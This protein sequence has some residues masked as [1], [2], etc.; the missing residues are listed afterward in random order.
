MAVAPRHGVGGAER[1]LAR[2]HFVQRHTARVEIASCIDRAIHAAGLLR[3]HVGERPSDD[4]GPFGRRRVAR[5]ERRNAEARQPHVAGH[6]IGEDVRRLDVFVDETALMEM[7]ERIS[8]TDGHAQKGWW[9]PR[10][11][12]QPGQKLAVGMLDHEC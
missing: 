3:R 5:P 12:E 9:V 2:E 10:P 6:V 7:S 4:V 11:A 8:K 1:K